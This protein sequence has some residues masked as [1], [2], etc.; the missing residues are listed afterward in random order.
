MPVTFRWFIAQ[1]FKRC[2]DSKRLFV[3]WSLRFYQTEVELE[4]NQLGLEVGVIKLNR[5]RTASLGVFLLAF[6]SSRCAML[7]EPLNF[8]GLP[9]PTSPKRQ[10]GSLGSWLRCTSAGILLIMECAW[11]QHLCE[12]EKRSRIWQKEK[13]NR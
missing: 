8:S 4:C 6:S 1:P 11:D 2:P 7:G 10:L 13:L 12:G 5:G 3:Y 9:F